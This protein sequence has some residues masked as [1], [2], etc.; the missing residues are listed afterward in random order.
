M[1]MR[2]CVDLRDFLFF[3]MLFLSMFS[4]I[5][6]VLG[7]GN[8]QVSDPDENAPALPENIAGLHHQ[9]PPLLNNFLHIFRYSLADFEF[10]IL[11]TN[12]FGKF[13]T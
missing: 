1:V 2:V 8:K 5:L 10:A 6:A 11:D 3:Y 4:I 12:E 13:E 7:V 9:I